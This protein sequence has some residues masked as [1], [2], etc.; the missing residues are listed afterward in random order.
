MIH[1]I[2]MDYTINNSKNIYA[3]VQLENNSID[4]EISKSVVSNKCFITIKI[5]GESYCD[6]IVCL[7]YTAIT[8]LVGTWYDSP[9]YGDFYFAYTNKE[10]FGKDFNIDELGKTLFL[11][12]DDSLF[13]GEID[14]YKTKNGND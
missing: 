13:E 1:K 10:N 5:N 6:G 4:I 11:F 8:R 14:E 3:T 12:Y 7:G 2:L 9:L